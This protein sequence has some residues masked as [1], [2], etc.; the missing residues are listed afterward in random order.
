VRKPRV[1]PDEDHEVVYERVAAVD[2]AKA[3]GVVC[4]RTPDP[5]RPGRFVN[6]IWE[7]V[8]A[9][10]AQIAE[11]GRELLRNKVQMVTLESTSDYWRIWFY[12]LESIGLAVQLVSAS[13]AKNLKGRPKTD[14]LDAMW[15]ARLTQWGMLRPSFVP[16]AAIRRV[17]DFTR[18]RTGLVRERTRVLQRLEELLL[19]HEALLLPD[20]GERPSISLPS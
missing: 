3:A 6:R 7:D 14:R 20:G 8:P 12:V 2:V 16:P 1:V 18:A 9:M 19:R 4:M 13:Q 11:L 15:L 10:R 5:A 17:R